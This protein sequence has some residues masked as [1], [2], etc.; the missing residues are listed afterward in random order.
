MGSIQ[1]K[2]DRTLIRALAQISF[3]V[4]ALLSGTQNA[5]AQVIPEATT[6][7]EVVLIEGSA[8]INIT[9]GARSADGSNLFHGFEQ[10]DL[11]AEQT[12]S[13]ITPGDL[14][15]V[16][17]K[18]AGDA[19][20]IDGL[21]Q[22][23][24][25]D[26]DL[27]LINPAGILFGPNAQLN[28]PGSFTATTATQLS[29]SE[30]WL[31]LL[32]SPD[33]TLD[34]ST[35]I[36]APTAFGFETAAPII[37]AGNLSVGTGR[38]LSLFGSTVINT[39]SLSAPAGEL[40]ITAV[41]PGHL[42]RLNQPGRL[43]TLEIIDTVPDTIFAP[44]TLSELLTG[45]GVPAIDTL[46]V[47]DDGTVTLTS[48]ETL[49]P[50]QPGNALLSGQLTATGHQGGSLNIFGNQVALLS[51]NLSAAGTYGGGTI[52]VGGDYQGSDLAPTAA[53]TGIDLH[54]TINVD[55]LSAG[56]GGQV[57]IW[58]NE[59]TQFYGTLSARGGETSG[60]GGFAE[61][62][63]K[64]SLIFDGV[65]DLDSFHGT[66]GELLFDPSNII[67]RE[68]SGPTSDP[69]ALPN[70]LSNVT[71]SVFVIY[72]ET[73]ESFASVT[74][75]A[76]N[77]IT[78]ESLSDNALT[79]QP[80]G[81]VRFETDTNNSSDG[82]FTMDSSDTIHV[83]GGDLTI[84]TGASGASIS[85]GTLSTQLNPEETGIGNTG[86]GN[87]RLINENPNGRISAQ[88][89]D[90][91]GAEVLLRSNSIDFEGG[92]G[93]IAGRIVTLETL[94][95]EADI[96][97]GDVDTS[98]NVLSGNVLDLST[99]D[100]AA[101]SDDIEQIIIGRSDGT[102]RFIL[103][104]NLTEETGNAF[105]RPVHLLGNQL[106]PELVSIEGPDIATNWTI[107]GLNSG[108]LSHYG[109]LTFSNIANLL[110][111]SGDDT[112]TLETST[113]QITNSIAG[114]DGNLTIIGDTLALP[115]TLSGNSELF[116]QTRT[117]NIPIEIGGL[118]GS[119]AD[120]AHISDIEYLGIQPTFDS[121]NI[122]DDTGGPVTLQSALLAASGL[123]LR[124]ASDIDTSAG[125]IRLTSEASPL[126]LA[127]GGQ[128]L[129]GALST[130]GGNIALSAPEGI[131]IASADTRST[132]IALPLG[133]NIEIDTDGF[134]RALGA[135]MPAQ[136][137]ALSLATHSEGSISIHHGGQSRP[138]A[139][140]N[141]SINGTLGDIS[142]QRTVLTRQNILGDF[143]AEGIQITTTPTP[144]TPT[145]ST[146]PLAPT[147][148]S[149]E[150]SL[151][152][153]ETLAA[154]I[155]EDQS[156]SS[157]NVIL[158]ENSDDDAAEVFT[159]IETAASSQFEQYLP[160]TG[161]TEAAPI[162]TLDDVKNTLAT[163][164]SDFAIQP[165]LLYAYFVPDAA[166]ESGAQASPHDQL[167]VMLITAQG[168]PV[169]KRQWGI[170]RAQVEAIAAEM[171]YQA[172]SQFSRPNDYLPPSQQ[173]HK[174]IIDPIQAELDHHNIDNLAFIM[175]EGLRTF[176]IAA[177]HNGEQFLIEQYSLGLM[178]TFSLTELMPT[179]NGINHLRQSQV[180]AM[181]A[182]QFNNQPPLPAVEAELSL[183]AGDIWEGKSFLNENFTLENLR[184]EIAKE[185]YGI[186]HLA[187][188]AVFEADDFDSSYIQLWDEQIT[189]SEL[190]SLNL[191]QTSIDLLILSACNTAIGN[192]NA[193]Y[194][195][196]GFAV[197]AGSQS[198][199]ASL[200]P[201]SDEGTLGFM[202]QFYEQYAQGSTRSEALRQ[203]QLN[204]LQGDLFFVNGT[205]IGPNQEEIAV[206]PELTE[207]G[208]WDFSHPF[209]WSAF[210][211]IGNPW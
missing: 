173:L 168:E 33:S 44:T 111:G 72:E 135:I 155:L 130:Q 78:I 205:I 1:K 56:D 4:L 68:G 87:I 7:T 203:A 64:L 182:S 201:V 174:W 88:A 186:V 137:E 140:G 97:L 102:G 101:L 61:I 170:T 109:P 40:N 198:A 206:I 15:N 77:D 124:S 158:A 32:H 29:F 207:S 110:S 85:V 94:S 197:N 200:W 204:M 144:L 91:G 71:P 147:S 60:N 16:I 169:K 41:E 176:P 46:R 164:Q 166:S 52:R 131:T 192:K 160:A 122:G 69:T 187:T 12:A 119:A 53:R 59:G 190:E 82:L 84:V 37:N 34:Y 157:F 188:H 146:S 66:Q 76:S 115:A 55:A 36:G 35:L 117:P 156:G 143:S 99:T 51:A 62:S 171:R 10:F 167:E 42:L 138:L 163:A 210:T 129:T 148:L 6:A 178:P 24:G 202:S 20:N 81:S 104:E 58:S 152:A 39:G 149:G 27:Y 179:N 95:P 74:L 50:E 67:I 189:L 28:L 17:G 177:L 26:A 43:L 184:T 47:N 98:G 90:A 63:S 57:Y 172:T 194:G 139:V 96:L 65:V 106:F 132:G 151:R 153:P 195:F 21:L 13:F 185:Q 9:G 49:L 183:I 162:A 145:P 191:S 123:T 136:L 199:L 83:P 30:Q 18:I 2:R 8:D 134:F 93:Q 45:N 181:G 105:T 75:Q 54:S 100:R 89:I 79:F 38:S 25:S 126:T 19:S 175:D 5:I 193:E 165:A 116:I 103:S 159:R 150:P 11:G 73:L 128:I 121:I 107:T 196:A 22:I 14:Q 142:N 141:A 108:S 31:Q 80:G 209:Y 120:I 113:A 70:V 86:I 92:P 127:A 161:R 3:A 112:V 154:P 133:G 180:L 118:Q 211:M 48:S 208:N 23:L 125:P 114:A